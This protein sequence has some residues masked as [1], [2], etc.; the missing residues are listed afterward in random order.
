MFNL[1]HWL[2][3]SETC[4][5]VLIP[6]SGIL[7]EL[8]SDN[9]GNPNVW[10]AR[11]VQEEILGNGQD[12]WFRVHVGPLSDVEAIRAMRL[13]LIENDMDFILLKIGGGA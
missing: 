5:K 9:G 1:E 11:K 7:L 8:D 10:T 2:R 3:N 4:P 12:V 6:T 13:K